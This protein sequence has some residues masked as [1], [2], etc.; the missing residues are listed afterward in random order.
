MDAQLE[1]EIY[2]NGR[3]RGGGRITM[4]RCGNYS[5]LGY[6]IY[7]YKKDKEMSN[8]YSSD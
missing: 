2:T 1:E 6:N 7:I 5:E 8:V 3:N 4:R